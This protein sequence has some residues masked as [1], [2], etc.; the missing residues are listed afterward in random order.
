MYTYNIVTRRLIGAATI[1]AVTRVLSVIVTRPLRARWVWLRQTNM[2]VGSS[3]SRKE[4]DEVFPNCHI[5][6][7]DRQC[8][9]NNVTKFSRVAIYGR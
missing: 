6:S 1:V 3:V 7:L 8:R 5:C 2:F 4:C 9:R